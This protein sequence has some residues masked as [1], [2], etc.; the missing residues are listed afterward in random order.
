MKSGNGLYVLAR[1]LLDS[2]SQLSLISKD[3]VGELGLTPF[4]N[5]LNIQGI[6]ESLTS[7]ISCVFIPIT[8]HKL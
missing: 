1:G 3:F 5:K 8:A 4:K 2:G 6:S 7:V